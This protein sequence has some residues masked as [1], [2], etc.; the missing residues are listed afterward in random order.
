M[1]A[2]VI[3]NNLLILRRFVTVLGVVA[4]PGDFF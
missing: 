2:A 3:R 4:S 1:P